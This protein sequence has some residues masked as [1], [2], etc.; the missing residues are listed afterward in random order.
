MKKLAN[1]SPFLLLLI[2]VFMMMLLTFITS[3]DT[4][5]DDDFATKSSGSKTAFIKISNP[6]K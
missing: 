4:S 5:Q 3:H 6:F 2:P 1:V